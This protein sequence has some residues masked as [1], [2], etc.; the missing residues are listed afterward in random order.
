MRHLVGLCLLAACLIGASPGVAQETIPPAVA[1]V[2]D[3]QR[4]MRE[5]KAATSIRD[6]VDAKRKLYQ[7]QIAR[8]EKRL[9]DADK[10]LTRQRAVLSAEAFGERRGAFEK[11]VADVQRLVQ[12]RRRELDQVSAAAL[13]EVRGVI[14]EIVG[15]LSEERGFNIVLPSSGVLLFSPKVDLTRDVI[16]RLDGR[17]P[18]VKVPE[19]VGQN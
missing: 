13:N 19:K 8:E 4:V 9:V 7:D 10:E 1:A 16:A 14:I 2:I 6:Q 3:Y 17:L 18:S 11:K 5:A 15:V 12:E